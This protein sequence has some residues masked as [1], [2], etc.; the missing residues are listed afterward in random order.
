MFKEK[1]LSYNFE[2]P[3]D[4]VGQVLWGANNIFQI[5]CQD[6][7]ERQCRLRGKTLKQS[8][9]EHNPLICGDFVV[10]T[11]TG[12]SQGLIYDRIKR[13]NILQRRNLK[14]GEPQALA[15][16]LDGIILLVSWSEPPLRPAFLD[17]LLVAAQRTACPILILLNKIDCISNFKELNHLRKFLRQYRNLDYR[18]GLEVWP[19]SMKYLQPNESNA[20]N[21]NNPE[22]RENEEP[23]KLCHLLIQVWLRWV[24]LRSSRMRLQKLYQALSGR[25]YAIL[26][27]SGV[28]KSSLCN[29]LFP[30]Q[31]QETRVIFTKMATRC[32]H[33]GFGTHAS[34]V[35]QWPILSLDR[36]PR[37]AQFFARN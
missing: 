27:A 29:Y 4:L 11:P 14:R 1:E 16:N 28:G 34:S 15:A 7:R 17:R 10:L 12:E 22:N 37:N 5:S 19:I 9:A 26:G 13:Y 24:Y 33:Y 36:Y 18:L 31:L 8:S 20:T 32:S 2:N 3:D 35:P 30:E 21:A 23:K 6:G 25:L